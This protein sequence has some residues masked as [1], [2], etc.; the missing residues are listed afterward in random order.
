VV[1]EGGGRRWSWSCFYEGGERDGIGGEKV[2]GGG[3]GVGKEGLGIGDLS[4]GWRKEF[5]KQKA[6]KGR[7]YVT[8]SVT[9]SDSGTSLKEVVC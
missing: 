7:Y 5:P 2:G 9:S 4:L 8:L 6:S 3:G 1:E